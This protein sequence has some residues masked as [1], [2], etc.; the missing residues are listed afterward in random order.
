[1]TAV[2]QCLEQI[3]HNIFLYVCIEKILQTFM[4]P[5]TTD[6]HSQIT[7]NIGLNVIFWYKSSVQNNFDETGQEPKVPRG[8]QSPIQHKTD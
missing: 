1:V 3:R 7:N 8:K 5:S 4:Y 6:M 2:A